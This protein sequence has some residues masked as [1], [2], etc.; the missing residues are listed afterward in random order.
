MSEIIRGN[1]ALAVVVSLGL[2][3]A[4][5]AQVPAQRGAP[6]AAPVGSRATV[7]T[8]SGLKLD[9]AV[10]G[11]GSEPTPLQVACVFEY[12]AGDLTRPPALPAALNGML[13]LDQALQGLISELRKSAQFEGHELETLL[14]TPPAKA[15]RAERVLLV[16]LG[17]RTKF[18]PEVMTR[19]G[20]VGMREALR[21]GVESY[22]HASDLKDAGIDSP[23]AAIAQN[24]LR[25]AIKAWRTEQ[26][27]EQ[28]GM[29]AHPSVRAL[30]LLAGPKF[31]D[32][33]KA[34]VHDSV[35]AP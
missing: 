27:L 19:V 18:T 9:V 17:D 26:Y 13:H 35:T 12:V 7:G 22:A 34:A 4:A 28:R 14:I 8:V 1:L 21:L 2:V 16:G 24:V 29:A 20:E 3:T 11:P 31:F 32:D 25:G 15:L 5:A 10:E 33:T 30:T 23:T 6:P